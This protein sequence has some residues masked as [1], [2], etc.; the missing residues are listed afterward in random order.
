MKVDAKKLELSAQTTMMA[1]VLMA[2]GVAS[3]FLGLS[4]DAP[5]IWR[6]FL[7]NHLF[8]QGL[9]IGAIFF[10]VIHYLSSSG[11]VVAVR[12]VTEAMAN[13]FMVAAA[14]TLVLFFGLGKI[15]P[16]TSHEFMSEHALHH[17]AAYFSNTFFIARVVAFLL[18]VIAI[19]Q[20]MICN[21]T[22]QDE[23]GGVALREQQK[24]FSA[25]YLVLFAPLFTVF[26][27]DLIKSLEPKW[28]STMFGV[29]V[30]I[31][32]V[33]AS[34]AMTIL[35]VKVLRKRG[36]L[37]LVREDHYHDLGK[38]M[39]G[40]SIFWGYIGVS[41]YLLIWYANLPEEITFYTAREVPGWLPISIL[42]PI[43]RFGIPFLGLLPR[44]AKRCDKY[45]GA[46]A[47]LVLFG[48]WID[49]NYLI[50]PTFFP[51]GFHIGWQDMGMFLGFLGAFIFTVRKFLAKHNTV[52]VKDPYLH[53]SV[54]HHVI[55]S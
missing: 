2:I 14:F 19:S 10:L 3:F 35:I 41:Q 49:L 47:C 34:I 25:I 48:E 50:M 43:L 11:W 29:Y 54:N 37:S 45:L 46:M 51:A 55:Y 24:T 53:E 28:F 27:V 7:L 32:F 31:G 23:E 44:A 12:R 5:R 15:Y 20:K 13:Y 1:I 21:S 52:P 30:F 38:Y 8:F 18:V 17:K 4:T 6:S 33:Q 16:W 36:H 22:R 42:L 39:F 26:S 9:S 40:F